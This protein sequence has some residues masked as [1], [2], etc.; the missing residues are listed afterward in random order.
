MPF[1]LARF[2]LLWGEISDL[3]ATQELLSWDQETMM[4]R[5]GAEGRAEVV[6]TVAGLR[7]R[8]LTSL[9]L[10]EGIK[11]TLDRARSDSQPSSETRIVG[12]RVDLRPNRQAL[13]LGG[14]EPEFDPLDDLLSNLAVQSEH[15]AQIAIVALRPEMTIVARIDQL[16]RDAHPILVPK[17]RP[18]EHRLHIELASD[19]G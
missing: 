15:V 1:D 13:C 18:F 16:R 19:L 2:Y 6:A 3:D 17:D 7:H 8:A 11:L 9:E 4:P 5:Q 14:C 12:L 10:V